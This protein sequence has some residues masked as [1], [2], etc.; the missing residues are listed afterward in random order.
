MSACFWV[1][2]RAAL[3]EQRRKLKLSATS[4][5]FLIV[6]ELASMHAREHIASTNEA[7]RT[8][9]SE[10]AKTK[11]ERSSRREQERGSVKVNHLFAQYI[12][13]RM[14][15][16]VSVSM[17]FLISFCSALP[18][19]NP[20]FAVGSFSVGWLNVHFTHSETRARG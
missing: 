1:A 15:M 4:P 2:L 13:D 12:A 14:Q 16:S 9:V 19:P 17:L 11:H 3:E 10:E 8:R 18:T 7:P 5:R 20:T 6:L